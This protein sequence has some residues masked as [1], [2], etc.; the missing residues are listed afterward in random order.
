M[1]QDGREAATEAAKQTAHFYQ[2]LAER[3]EDAETEEFAR[4]GKE[5]LGY[6]GQEK[7][8][9]IFAY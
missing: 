5:L 3:L 9:S 8:R 4:R 6:T 2:Y 7:K 1:A